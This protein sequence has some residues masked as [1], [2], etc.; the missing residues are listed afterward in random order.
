MAS[1]TILNFDHERAE[2][3]PEDEHDAV[4][5]HCYN[6]LARKYNNLLAQVERIGF[7]HIPEKEKH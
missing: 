3:V 6:I 7:V 1:V 5:S 4:C 2:I